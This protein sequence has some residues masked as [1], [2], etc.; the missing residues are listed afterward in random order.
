MKTRRKA[1]PKNANYQ[2]G[3][4]LNRQEKRAQ[5]RNLN[6]NP[7]AHAAKSHEPTHGQPQKEIAP[8]RALTDAQGRY[9][10]SIVANDITFCVGP[11]GTGKSF[12]AGGWAAEQIKEGLFEN[13]I[14]TRPGV[15]AGKNWGALPGTLEEKFAPFMEPFEDVLKERLGATFY[16]YLAKK[17][18]I[19]PYPLEFMRGK[20]FKN[21]IVILDEAQNATEDQLLML[22]TRIGGDPK[23]GEGSK[24]IING[25][26]TQCDIRNSGL[27]DAIRILKPVSSIGL[28]EFTLDDIVRH[29]I[30]KDILVAY[31]QDRV[32]KLG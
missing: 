12:V 13:L 31:E 11:Q 30:I 9:L 20:T 19:I 22:M 3:G 29:G 16:E 24:I 15:E 8:L 5:K 32:R 1:N 18:R 2:E 25:G 21:S 17:K 7:D 26:L 27:K 10:S 28:V 4:E 6:N 14:I 23:I